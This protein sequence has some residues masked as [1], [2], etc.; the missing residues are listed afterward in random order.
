MYDS[1][2]FRIDKACLILITICVC[3]CFVL[4]TTILRVRG[5][6]A[7]CR[8]FGSA[9]VELGTNLC[10]FSLALLIGFSGAGCFMKSALSLFEC[11]IARHQRFVKLRLQFA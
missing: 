9:R 6:Q 3:L 5:T 1:I 10:E 8:R 11:V 7:E 4:D 2:L